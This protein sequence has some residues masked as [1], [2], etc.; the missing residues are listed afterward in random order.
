MTSGD[1]RL[2]KCDIS[3]LSRDTIDN[4]FLLGIG[5]SVHVSNKN[6]VDNT[7]CGTLQHPCQT[8]DYA[9]TNRLPNTGGSILLH[10][11]TGTFVSY[12]IDLSFKLFSLVGIGDKAVVYSNNDTAFVTTKRPN[13]AVAIVIKNI[14]FS[15]PGRFLNVNS[16]TDY[17]NI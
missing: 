17:S 6:S 9:V 2:I 3:R 16:T 7:S 10:G 12:G 14:K 4:S 8:I 11:G 15:S 1:C 5:P 13:H